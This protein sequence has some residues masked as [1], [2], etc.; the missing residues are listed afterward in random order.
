MFLLTIKTE[1]NVEVASHATFNVKVFVGLRIDNQPR[2]GL[3]AEFGN[4][5]LSKNLLDLL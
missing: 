3:D 2:D 4:N 1:C 5:K